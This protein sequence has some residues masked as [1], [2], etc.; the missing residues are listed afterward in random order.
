LERL[1]FLVG[2]RRK[3]VLSRV[4][5]F[6]SRIDIPS[7]LVGGIVRDTILGRRSFDIDIT[8]SGDSIRIA[9]L[10]QKRLKGRLKVYKDFKTASIEL[11][12]VRIDVARTRK[13]FYPSPGHLPLVKPGTLFDDLKRRDF[14]I[15]A[16]AFGISKKNFGEIIDPFGGI[17]DIKKGVIRVL[18]NKSFIDDPTRIFRALRY[19][20]RFNFTLEPKTEDLMRE[21]IDNGMISLLSG[22]RI[23]N[24]LELILSED[25]FLETVKDLT[26]YEIYKIDPEDMRLLSRA[27]PLK[28]HFYL[29]CID[30][31]KLP[32]SLDDKKIVNDLKELRRIALL[33]KNTKRDSE[34]YF[35][36]FPLNEKVIG[37]AAKLYPELR[38]RVKR[39]K[40][41]KKVKPLI[42]GNDLKKMGIKPGPEFKKLLKKA[43]V[44]QIDE[45]I[46]AKEEI[47]KRLKDG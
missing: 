1:K 47:I 46:N 26:D 10:L 9:Q 23:L 44:L 19:K 43:F 12:K 22:Q 39:Y 31:S 16:I 6:F 34:I 17:E 33:I 24:E 8:V 35:L 11:P 37:I 42:N 25:S 40:F 32:L 4:I 18:H 27:G 14:S 20:N 45:K 3:S 30:C 2:K 36:F 15:N 38:P 7:Y 29:S 13:E 5:D 41:L 21:A 28:F